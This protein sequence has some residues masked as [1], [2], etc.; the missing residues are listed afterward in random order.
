MKTPGSDHMINN[1]LIFQICAKVWSAIFQVKNVW[2]EYAY[3]G[4]TERN[5]VRLIL[6]NRMVTIGDI[7][8]KVMFGA[9]TQQAL[10]SVATLNW[11]NRQHARIR[12]D[13]V[14]E[15]TSCAM[16]CSH[17]LRNIEI[18]SKLMQMIRKFQ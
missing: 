12:I 13:F 5:L 9:I 11:T 8:F 7:M 15:K 16:V 14:R 17:C 18:C 3:V 1:S 4:I 2:L 6:Y 10:V